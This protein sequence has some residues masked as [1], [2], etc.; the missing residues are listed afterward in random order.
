MLE[1]PSLFTDLDQQ[2][3]LKVEARKGPIDTIVVDRIE[4]PTAN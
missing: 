2:L 3:G 1:W 4:K